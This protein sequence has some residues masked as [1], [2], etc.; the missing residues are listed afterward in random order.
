MK[1]YA[2]PDLNDSSKIKVEQRSN[3]RGTIA[4]VPKELVG[5]AIKIVD[6][7]NPD[8]PGVTQK[9]VVLD[10]QAEAERLIQEEEEERAKRERKNKRRD[11]IARLK[12]NKNNIDK[13]TLA[14]LRPIIKVLVEEILGE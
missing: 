14:N 7:E 11:R 13:L 6:E 12:Q 9:K 3:D 2:L 4:E 10:E 8:M 1:Y 5:K